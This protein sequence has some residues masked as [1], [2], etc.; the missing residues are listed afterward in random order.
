MAA[1]LRSRGATDQPAPNILFIL[2]DDVGRDAIGC[3]GGTS[4]PTPNIDRLAEEG[5]R[6]E[7]V[8]SA[9]VCHPSRVCLLTGRYPVTLGN[10]G[11]GSFPK[12][13]EKQTFAHELKKAGYATAVAGK[14][15]LTLLKKDPDQP[16]RLGFDD[17]SLFG[18]HEGPRFHKPHIWQNGKRRDDVADRYGPDVY[19][20]FL[21][22]FMTRNKARP[23]IAYFPMALCHDVS[24]DFR[25]PPPYGPGKD[26]YENFGEMM[27]EMDR[28]IGRIVGAVDKLGLT[29]RTLV[30]F[31]T[32]NGTAGRTIVR[33][34]AKGFEKESN[35]S[36]MGDAR[37]PG[38]KG[39]LTDWGIRVPTI[40]R[41]PG[42]VAAGAVSEELV[43]F[44]DFLPTFSKLAGLPAPKYKIDGRSFAGVLT[45]GS[46]ASRDWIYSESRG[47]YCVRSRKWKLCHDGKL[48]DMENGPGERKPI[49]AAADTPESARARETLRA[50]IKTLRVGQ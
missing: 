10:P 47:K 21:V 45:G 22:D 27:A 19:C 43:D 7:H 5:M 25:P 41:W 26:R 49:K 6:F 48:F 20:E 39:K 36:R 24:D 12:R 14:W 50:A 33:H 2:A 9:P 32:D 40:A 16:H 30:I 37:V 28:I 35:V 18:W 46:H 38:G 23:F 15:Q 29:R 3:Y 8:Y 1:G 34:K 31:T 11:W 17:Y 13:A 42:K 4:Y 44:S